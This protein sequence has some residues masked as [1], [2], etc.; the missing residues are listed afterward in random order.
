MYKYADWLYKQP[1]D[2]P[3][4][5]LEIYDEVVL[6]PLGKSIKEELVCKEFSDCFQGNQVLDV[7]DRC[8]KIEEEVAKLQFNLN[9]CDFKNQIV[10][11]INHL[12]TEG[13]ERDQ[14]KR[15]FTDIDNNKGQLMLSTLQDQARKDSLFS[16]IQIEDAAK[17]KCISE[18][19]ND[20]QMDQILEL[21]R[22]ELQRI[23]RDNSDMAFK[24]DLGEYVERIIKN[25]LNLQL[26]DESLRI[27]PVENEQGGQDL[28]VHVNNEK[29]YYIEVKSR[30]TSDKSVLMSTLQHRTSYEQKDRYA[31]CVVDMMGVDK[32]DVRMHRYPPFEEVENRIV[33]LENIGK[34]NET[35]KAATE[36]NENVVHVNGGYQVL[37]SQKV[38]EA[39]AV[40]FRQF[41]DDLKEL[42]ECFNKR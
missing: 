25:E 10:E 37:V 17:L 18:L 9:G 4:R 23:E 14:W 30:W 40:S 26:G 2:T 15:L 1:S 29:T 35:L 3:D 21:G 12:T 34:L 28:I 32:E 20:P 36:N 16:L 6:G 13:S 31:L 33:V 38:I 24:K 19:A 11:I 5:A 41:L 27:K 42:V 22:K 7:I 8:K 39:N